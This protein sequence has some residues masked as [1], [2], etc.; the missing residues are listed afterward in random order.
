MMV[1][2]EM[3]VNR[4]H[5]ATWKDWENQCNSIASHTKGVPGIKTEIKVP[6][7]A[8]MVPHLH[9]DWDHAAVGKTPGDVVKELR[10]GTPSIEVR[11]GSNKEF[12]VAVW[13]LEPGE[14]RTVGK[15][16]GQVLNG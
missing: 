1:A 14:Y 3:F 8:N 13:M 11:P 12:V 7:L 9:V 6:E 5:D 15:R 10:E 4:D 16:L 2:L